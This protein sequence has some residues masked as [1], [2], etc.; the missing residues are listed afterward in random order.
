MSTPERDKEQFVSSLA[1]GIA[2]LRAFGPG[3]P[4]LTLSQVAA[5][6]DLSPA[7]ARRFLLTLVQLGYL[8]QID[9]RFVLTPK[10]IDNPRIKCRVLARYAGDT[11]DAFRAPEIG[12]ALAREQYR[13]GADVVFHASGGTGAGVFRAARETGQRAI[14][15]DVDQWRE[16][17]GLVLTSMV[18][19][20]DVAVY[21]VMRRTRRGEFTA[22]V[23][24]Y[25]LEEN[26]I[27]WVDD[28]HNA[29]LVPAD[30]RARV[31]TLRAAVVAQLIEVPSIVR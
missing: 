2:V 5:L 31:E 15:V 4:E 26:G 16:A 30:T 19:R 24:T 14:G 18:K 20:I 23:Q 25:G 1:R 12:Y 3:T 10:V 7:V 17:P 9:R 22:G 8:R 11:P 6:T 29:T 28:A 13:Q 21:D 27:G